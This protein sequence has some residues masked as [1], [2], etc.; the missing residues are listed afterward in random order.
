MVLDRVLGRDILTDQ[1]D[2]AFFI[3]FIFVLIGFI[4]SYLIFSAGMSIAMI[5]FSSLLIL[6]Y[7]IKI[8]RPESS[9]YTSVFDKKNSTI[10]FF[11]YLFLGMALAYTVLFG[12]LNPTTLETAFAMQLDIVNPGRTMEGSFT[13]AGLE[14]N[15]TQ[16]FMEIVS[17]NI[18]I[19]VIAILMSFVYG[20]GA[21][22]IL[23]YNASIAGIVYGSNINLFIWGETAVNYLFQF[24][25]LYLPHTI[26]EITAYLLAGICGVILSK[27]VT[28]KN[29]NLIQRDA[30]ILFIA[31]IALILIGGVVEVTV[32]FLQ[33]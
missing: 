15:P 20:S 18:I 3:G 23:N 33:F 7:I 10:K 14:F 11:G 9:H 19:V 25:I 4:S 16:L 31:A 21:I 30:M 12:V 2:V 32:P 1:P 6:P 8:M 29:K 26:I 24:P 17:N 28:R 13:A 27:P 22:F 5:G